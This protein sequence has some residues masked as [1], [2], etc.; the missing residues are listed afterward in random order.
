MYH[1]A[2]RA[3]DRRNRF[4]YFNLNITWTW[5]VSFTL[6]PLRSMW[7]EPGYLFHRNLAGVQSDFGRFESKS[8]LCLRRESKLLSRPPSHYTIQLFQL[9]KRGGGLFPSNASNG[10]WTGSNF[11]KEQNNICMQTIRENV[12]AKTNFCFTKEE[13]S[14]LRNPLFKQR[15]S[16]RKENK[17]AKSA[18]LRYLH[19]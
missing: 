11:V 16:A 19:G 17:H 3:G 1:H 2:E 15:T 5:V 7:M 6:W 10:I 14:S 4:M 9:Q 18:E 8:F 12:V 13:C